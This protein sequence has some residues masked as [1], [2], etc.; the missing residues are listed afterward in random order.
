MNSKNIKKLLAY[1]KQ[2]EITD[3]AITEKNGFHVLRGEDGLNLHHLK[4]PSKLENELGTVYRNLLSLAPNDLV[5]G[6]YFKTKDNAFRLSIIPDGPSEKIIINTV[7]K[8]KKVLTLSHLGLGRQE[9]QL[10][11][12]FLKKRSGLIVV[13]SAENQGK[14]TTLYSLLQKINRTERACYSLEK[15]EELDLDEV[16]KLTATEDK[17]LTKLHQILK[18]DSEVVMIDDVSDNLI[19]ETIKVAE[20]GR[21][22]LMGIK[23]DNAQDLIKKINTYKTNANLETLVIF[24]KIIKKNCPRCLKTYLIDESEE[25]IAK[26]W[27]GEKNY[28]PKYF[29]SSRGCPLCNHSGTNGQIA[30]FNLTSLKEQNINIIST[31]AADILQ[32]AANGLISMSKFISESKPESHQKL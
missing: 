18:S 30:V 10:I 23:T 19:I 6:A 11:Q 3:L 26:Y 7:P 12:N 5:S 15:Y 9:R 13:A 31:L 8:T 24:Q 16:N 28:K 21:L 25:L 4:L 1:A 2:H 20:T 17:Y 27:P 14:T 22:V 32:K 29:F